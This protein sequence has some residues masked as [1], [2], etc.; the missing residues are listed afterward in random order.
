V[1]GTTTTASDGS[2]GLGGGAA[3][4]VA[5]AAAAG[6]DGGEGGG[7]VMGALAPTRWGRSGRLLALYWTIALTKAAAAYV[8]M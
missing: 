1:G 4:V 2:S 5:A 6:V 8:L 3:V 7:C